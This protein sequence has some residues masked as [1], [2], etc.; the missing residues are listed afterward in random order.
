MSFVPMGGSD[1]G[2]IRDGL[3]RKVFSF[4]GEVFCCCW[5]SWEDSEALAATRSHRDSDM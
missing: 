1:V 4:N 3:G 2:M 5:Q